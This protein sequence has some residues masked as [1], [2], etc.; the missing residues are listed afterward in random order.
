[1]ELIGE[2]VL[3]GVV[4]NLVATPVVRIAGALD[5]GPFRFVLTGNLVPEL[6]E[7][8]DAASGIHIVAGSDVTQMEQ[9]Q[10][11]FQVRFNFRCRHSEFPG[12]LIL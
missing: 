2:V 10:A 1:M 9:T 12:H 11:L 3:L 5:G 7:H 6:I 4:E 8:G